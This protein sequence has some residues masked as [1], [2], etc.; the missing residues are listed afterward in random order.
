MQGKHHRARLG[1]AQQIVEN[2]NREKGIG[3]S[4]EMQRHRSRRD[5]ADSF[6]S[7]EM[8]IHCDAAVFDN[9]F[10]KRAGHTFVKTAG[11]LAFR[12]VLFGLGSVVS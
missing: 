3:L 6:Q 1:T 7:V 10:L 11:R 9:H 2:H 5:G 8:E 12:I 4:G